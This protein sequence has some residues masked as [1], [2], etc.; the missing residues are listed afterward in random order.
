MAWEMK[1]VTT[2]GDEATIVLARIVET[3]ETVIK[4]HYRAELDGKLQT[5]EEW[6]ANIKNEI[7]GLLAD[8][9]AEES[10]EVDITSQ[11]G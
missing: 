11:V 2:K 7:V 8:M 3:E 1:T 4:K 10:A 5:L 9:N 6:R